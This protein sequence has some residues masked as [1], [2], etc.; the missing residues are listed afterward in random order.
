MRTV[1]RGTLIV[2]I[3]LLMTMGP[4]AAGE[5]TFA[6][7]SY[8]RPTIHEA[9]ITTAMRSTL[10]DP[11]S[12]MFRGIVQR[13]GLICGYVN[14]RNGFGGYS[15]FKEFTISDGGKVRMNDGSRNFANR[16]NSTCARR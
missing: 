12:A 5:S 3:M 7:T 11:E 6:K 16:W 13:P 1:S 4:A 15:G 8:V 2:K 10:R 9:V 14:A